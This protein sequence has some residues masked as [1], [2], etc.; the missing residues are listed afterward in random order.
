MSFILRSFKLHSDYVS[1]EKTFSANLTFYITEEKLSWKSTKLEKEDCV[2]KM[3]CLEEC[4]SFFPL[5]FSSILPVEY[6]Y[7]CISTRTQGIKCA[8]HIFFIKKGAQF[9]CNA[10]FLYRW[11]Y[12]KQWKCILP[13][14]HRKFNSSVLLNKTYIRITSIN[15]FTTQ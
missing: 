3:R 7:L 2:C 4:L 1:K 8:S 15:V 11:I 14:F 9:R 13:M 12:E 5:R 6:V 10:S